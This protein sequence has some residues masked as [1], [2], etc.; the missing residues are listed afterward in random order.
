MAASVRERLEHILEATANIRTLLAGKT[1]ENLRAEPFTRAALERFIEII[2][3]ASRHLPP[4]LKDKHPQIAWVDI[5]NIGNRLRHGYDKVD[6]G[7]LWDVFAFDIDALDQ[8]VTQ[9]KDEI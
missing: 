2:S 4:E 8:A 9:M 1:I 3:E 6:E 5:A 7:I